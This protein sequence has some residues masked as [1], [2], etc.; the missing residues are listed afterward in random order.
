MIKNIDI[1]VCMAAMLTIA[2]GILFFRTETAVYLSFTFAVLWSGMILGLRKT[3]PHIV[4]FAIFEILLHLLKDVHGVGNLPLLIVYLR[5]LV[6]AV[7]MAG[8]VIKAPVGRLIASLDKLGIPRAATI[9]LAVMFRFMPTVRAEY[10]AI[11]TA[12][13]YRGVGVSLKSIFEIHKLFEYTIVPLLIRTTKVAD[14][15][16]ASAEVRGMKLEDCQFTGNLSGAIST[17]AAGGTGAFSSLEAVQRVG[18][19]T[20]GQDIKL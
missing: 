19:Q 6:I 3:V 12:Q 2:V 11:R 20:F 4:L 8:P 13:R 5:R 1:R 18:K 14:E 7:I 15:L 17:T 10:T 9:S 16:T